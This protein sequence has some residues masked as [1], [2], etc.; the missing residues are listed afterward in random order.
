[1]KMRVRSCVWW[2]KIDT[3]L[4]QMVATCKVCMRE[5]KAPPK[6]PLNPWPTPN[7]HWSR[8]HS[9][10]LGPIEARMF[11][12]VI[13]AYSK[14]PEVFDM[15]SNTQSDKTIAKFEILFARHGLP[16]QLVTDNGPQY[17]SEKFKLFVQSNNIKQTYTSPWHPASNGSAENFVGTFKDKVHKML[18]SGKK[19]NEAVTKFLFDY[20]ST[21]HC[22]TGRT[23]AYMM[24]K[25]ELRTKLDCLRPDVSKQIENAQLRQVINRSGTRNVK[26]E[27]GERV[28]VDERSNS[29]DKRTLGI[30]KAQLSPVNFEVEIALGKLWKRHVDQ[31]LK[32]TKKINT[33]NAELKLEQSR[34]EVNT[35]R[36]SQR[37][38]EKRAKIMPVS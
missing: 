27:V 23:P 25:R 26:F 35:I 32:Y 29:G 31:I 13:D 33:D 3:D 2:P 7:K 12:I 18:K 15:G 37:L 6:T 4:E 30:I 38:I 34:P 1:M 19:L 24:Y 28:W 17:T 8:I 5:R 10:F 9:D 36:K 16:H 21:E 22:S 20:R 11:L 14:W